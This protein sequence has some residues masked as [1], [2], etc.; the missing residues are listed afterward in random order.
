[1][2]FGIDTETWT[3]IFTGISTLVLIISVPIAIM[4]LISIV[5]AFKL[6]AI[7]KFL[8]EFSDTEEDRKFLFREFSFDEKKQHSLP[9]DEEKK[10]NNVI[11]SLNRIGLLID[12]GVIKHEV[13]FSLCH[14]VIIRCWYK[15][16][17]YITFREKLLGARYGRR[18]RKLTERAKRF[19]DIRPFQRNKPIK[20]FDAN[21]DDTI[22][23][24]T[25]Y[26]K[27]IPGILQKLIWC[28]RYIFHIY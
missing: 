21:G 23:Y 6:E 15:L 9:D 8:K 3:L 22:I 19:H 28:I 1:M 7:T 25:E 24:R 27:G 14:T 20:I 10:I 17:P 12:S 4:N 11:N 16:E 18:I 5:K 13:V 2:I 26:K